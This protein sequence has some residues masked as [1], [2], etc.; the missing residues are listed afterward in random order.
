[1][2]I[3]ICGLFREEDIDYANETAPDYVGF[4]FAESKRRVTPTLAGRL[5][6]RLSGAILPVGVFV[7]APVEEIATLYRAGVFSIAQLHGKE[8]ETFIRRL[9]TACDAPIIKAF[10]VSDEVFLRDTPDS[11]A[12]NHIQTAADYVLFDSGAGSGKT[13]DWRLTRLLQPP[14]RPVFLAG[15]IGLENIS[16]AVLQAPFCIDVSSGAETNGV[17]DREKMAALVKTVHASGKNI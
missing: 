17:K 13:F 10:R 6:A 7:D 8:D 9:K 1:M 14:P 11:D 12:F 2:K 3:K 4:V 16:R 15:G 5:R